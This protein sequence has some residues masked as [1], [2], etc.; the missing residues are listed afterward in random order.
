LY[1][2]KY[3]DVDDRTRLAAFSFLTRQV[4]LHGDVLPRRILQDGFQ[5]DGARVPLM[6]PQGIF[7][8][9]VMKDMPLTITTVPLVAGKERPYEDEIAEGGLISYKYRGSD[10][11]HREN[12]GL[13]RA[14][15]SETPLIYLYG[16]IPG[17]YMPVWPVFI[18]GD[19]PARLSF[20][21][22]VDEAHALITSQEPTVV[23][24]T[25]REY[26][27]RLTRHRLH[28]AGFRERVIHAYK[29]SCSVCRLRHHQLLDAA[30]ILP[31][32]HPLGEPTVPNG[33]AL[34]KLHHAAFDSNIIGVRPDLVIEVSD[35]VLEEIDGP[36]LLH[37]L[38]GFHGQSLRVP[39][40]ADLK[41]R[42]EFLEE[43]YESFR[44][45]G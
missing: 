4:E 33:L 6:G 45:A 20:T 25:R 35:R 18:V 21:V 15:Q 32:G 44:A 42:T 28:Q 8:P 24:E 12:A 39:T 14:M 27:T 37:G 1:N 5:Q 19:D 17:Y 13:R 11:N 43:R 38:Q 7:K 40:Q 31:D 9:A 22:A 26:V 16:I 30:H 23:T 36:M 10:P 29:E 2:S 41:P 34:C 3:M